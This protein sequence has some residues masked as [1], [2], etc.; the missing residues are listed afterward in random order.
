MGVVVPVSSGYLS[1]PYNFS[2]IEYC[3]SKSERSVVLPMTYFEAYS[4]FQLY[5][6]S[7]CIKLESE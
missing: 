6:D 4:N 5:I 7:I 1:M 3:I 2:E